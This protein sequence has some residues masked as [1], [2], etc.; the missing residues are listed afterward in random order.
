MLAL[1]PFAGPTNLTCSGHSFQHN[2]VLLRTLLDQPSML[3]HALGKHCSGQAMSA[4]P[5]LHSLVSL[6][7][8]I[9]SL[10]FSLSLSPCLSN[11]HTTDISVTFPCSKKIHIQIRIKSSLFTIPASV[12]SCLPR[13]NPSN[14]FAVQIFCYT[15]VYLHVLEKTCISLLFIY[16]YVFI[17]IIYYMYHSITCLSFFY[18]TVSLQRLLY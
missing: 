14:H 10:S 5:L 13:N 17:E 12:L 11:N 1:F 18:F 9:L 16:V 3:K 4:E 15:T 8:L 7:S 2:L 6:C